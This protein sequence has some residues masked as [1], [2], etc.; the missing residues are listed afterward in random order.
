MYQRQVTEGNGSAFLPVTC[1]ATHFFV[2]NFLAFHT[3]QKIVGT[4]KMRTLPNYILLIILFLCLV[5]LI[6]ISV[7]IGSKNISFVDIIKIIG[8]KVPETFAGIQK[9]LSTDEKIIFK[10][11]IPRVL[12]AALVGA[13][14]AVSGL[15]YQSIL[16]NPLAEPFTLGISSGASF[17]AALAIFISD[18][19]LRYNRLPLFPF[20]L[21]GG[22][23]SISIIFF[24]S[25]K[26]RISL[27]TLLFIGICISFFFNAFLTLFLSLLGNRSYEVLLWTFGT[28][29][30]PPDTPVFIAYFVVSIIGIIIIFFYNRHLDAFY[31]S[32]D[33][34]KSLGINTNITRALLFFITSF[35]TIIAVSFCGIIGFIGLIIPH[36]SRIIFG[37]RH[38]ILI[39]ACAILGS[40]L[41]L[42]SDDIARTIVGFFTDYGRELPIGV[43]TSLF[44]APFFL[45]FL[46]KYR[47][48]L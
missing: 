27:F 13:V 43:I 22:S 37:Q 15:I 7:R 28:F 26:K 39:P 6:L 12:L 29:T 41:L 1:G 35:L 2:V 44:G 14:L 20:T 24:F 34:T 45:Y 21:I 30:N 25:L 17:G 46:L 36:L 40:I 42:L 8:N 11:R 48:T 47:S 33:I 3:A 19:F 23:I 4:K 31:F 9:D 5:F 16:K 38:K 18:F 10:L 32:D